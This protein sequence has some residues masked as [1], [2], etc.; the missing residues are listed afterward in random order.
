MVSNVSQQAAVQTQRASA[1]VANVLATLSRINPS[2]P[3]RLQ[4]AQAAL[5]RFRNV[6]WET[7]DNSW[8]RDLA[9]L[10]ASRSVITE[11]TANDMLLGLKGR[12]AGYAAIHVQN[13][14]EA[15]RSTEIADEFLYRADAEVLEQL[16][17]QI[18]TLVDVHRDLSLCAAVLMR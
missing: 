10:I 7:A 8:N 13:V 1:V 11:N 12:N 16:D 4:Q 17:Q 9:E 14:V 18:K 15:L 6:L 5:K 3:E 2:I